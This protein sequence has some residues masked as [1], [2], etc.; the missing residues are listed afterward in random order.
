MYFICGINFIEIHKID[1]F[2]EKNYIE[3][4]EINIITK[5]RIWKLPIIKDIRF[6]FYYLNINFEIIHLNF[7]NIYLKLI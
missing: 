1:D 6:E 3:N 2:D 4:S 7:W 5:F